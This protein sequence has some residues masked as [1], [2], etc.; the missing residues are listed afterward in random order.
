MK[1]VQIKFDDDVLAR[2]ID[3]DPKANLPKQS[4]VQVDEKKGSG[5]PPR[6]RHT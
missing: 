4:F 3:I 6:S 1:K 2:A 5:G